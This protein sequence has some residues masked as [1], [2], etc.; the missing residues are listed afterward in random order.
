MDSPT[1]LDQGLS[2]F[3]STG[4]VEQYIESD[5][6]SGVWMEC[7]SRTDSDSDSQ[8]FSYTAR[9]QRQQ[10]NVTSWYRLPRTLPSHTGGIHL[11]LCL[12][13]LRRACSRSLHHSALFHS[14]T[15]MFWQ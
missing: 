14:S 7:Q 1:I 6:Y 10:R 2:R 5:I 4:I 3:S 8:D 13:L 12:Q 11:W 9:S 15:E